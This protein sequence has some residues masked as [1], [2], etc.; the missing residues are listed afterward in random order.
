MASFLQGWL[1]G[2]SFLFFFFY[3]TGLVGAR[4]PVNGWRVN[5]NVTPTTEI[6][7]HTALLL[8]CSSHQTR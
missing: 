3:W 7:L 2:F 1:V 8:L 4:C 6:F 5:N